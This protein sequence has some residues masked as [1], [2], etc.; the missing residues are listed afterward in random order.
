M[1]YNLKQN[2]LLILFDLYLMEN[3]TKT[4]HFMFYL[5]KCIDFSEYMPAPN[6]MQATFF[7]QEC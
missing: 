5:I 3:S 7:K 4:I 6:L 2:A 1:V